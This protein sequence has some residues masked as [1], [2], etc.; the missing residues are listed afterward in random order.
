MLSGKLKAVIYG[1]VLLAPLPAVAITVTQAWFMAMDNDPVYL[2]AVKEQLAGEEY[3]PIGRAG[4]LPEVSLSYQRAPRNWQR[5]QS[6]QRNR[7]GKSAGVTQHQQYGSHSGSLTLTQ[8]LFDFEAYTRY[9]LGIVQKLQADER[10]RSSLIDLQNRLVNAWLDLTEAQ[11]KVKL[12]TLHM[13]A[14]EEQ[15]KLTRQQFKAGEMSLTDVTEIQSALSI[16]ISDRLTALDTLD[17]ARIAFSAMT[18]TTLSDTE[19]LPT[20]TDKPLTLPL[21]STEYH[22]WEKRARVNNPVILAARH[23]VEQM[24]Y[25]IDSRRAAAYPRVQLYAMHSESNSGSDNS[26]HQKYRTQ[27]VGL[28]VSMAIFSGGSVSASTRQAAARYEQAKYLHDAQRLKTF[29]ELKKSLNIFLHGPERIKAYRSAVEA[30]K[31]NIDATRKSILA[32]QRM[33]VDLLKAEQDF[34]KTEVE[35]AAVKHA[36]IK[37]WFGLLAQAGEISHDNFRTLDSYFSR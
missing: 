15:H 4:L 12:A 35:L 30:A 20:L 14:L 22:Y 27:S 25:E 5:Q 11:Q 6:Q 23:D 36:V 17:S 28:Q 29:S 10:Y 7:A 2:A 3:I 37:A 32:G 19:A 8:P 31:F 16:A 13:H 24:H 18:G 26:V 33:T 21:A 34:Y 9:R 1:L